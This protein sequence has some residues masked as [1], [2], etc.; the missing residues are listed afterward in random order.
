MKFAQAGARVDVVEINPAMVPVAQRYFDFEPERV[1]LTLS[2]GR[3]FLNAS[4]KQYDVIIVDAFLGDA[5]PSH[6]MTREA[7][8]AMRRLLRPGGVVVIDCLGN[9][10]SGKDFLVASV[11]QTLA[12][13]FPS[14]RIHCDISDLPTA[15]FVN[16]CFVAATGPL[17]FRLPLSFD[18]VHPSL[19][20]KVAAAFAQVVEANPAHGMLLTDDYNPVD[21]YDAHNREKERR[22]IAMRMK[23]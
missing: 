9:L 7:F 17:V 6:L 4:R 15:N 11:Q 5:A 18:T 13:V 2:D 10:E 22:A 20:E 3:Q 12:N 19:R 14:V 16:F 8:T 23:P 21:Y 1:H